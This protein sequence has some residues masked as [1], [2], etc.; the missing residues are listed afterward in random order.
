NSTSPYTSLLSADGSTLMAGSAGSL[1][2][3]AGTWTLGTISNPN[4][5]LILLNGQSVLGGY[6]V[7]LEVANKGDL[8][9]DNAQGQWWEWN[10][11]G[12]TSSTNPSSTP[13]AS[14]PPP[15]PA[16]S[17][18][19]S[20]LFSGGSGSLAT[21]AGTWTFDTTTANGGHL[22]LLNGQSAAGGAA[23]E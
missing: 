16:L 7:E 13:P 10:G 12:W 6:A 23:S 11:S 4:G 17:A 15:P 21:G 9:A 3:S 20:T 14:P 18:D 5:N 19:G 22:I 8:Y 2:T 1:L